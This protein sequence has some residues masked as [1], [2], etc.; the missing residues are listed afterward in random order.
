MKTNIVIPMKA[1]NYSKTRLRHCFSRAQREKLALRMF[2]S[3][4]IFF[5]ENFPEYHVLVVTNSALILLVAESHGATVLVERLPG[6]NQAATSASVWSINHGFSSQLLIPADIAQLDVEE[7]NSLLIAKRAHPSVLLVPAEDRGT[8]ALLTTP[9]DAIT[10]S[11]GIDSSEAHEAKA[12]E[13]LI[14]FQSFLLPY[15]ALDVDTPSDVE[16]LTATA[17]PLIKGLVPQWN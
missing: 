17:N 6:L 16:Q 10:F 9:P 7:I 4:L 12:A 8:N 1:P 15:L 11:Y 13:S 14:S 5:K 2:E 3:T